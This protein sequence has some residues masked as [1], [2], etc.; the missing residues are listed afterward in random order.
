MYTVL[1]WKSMLVIRFF[2][3]LFF[4]FLALVASQKGLCSMVLVNNKVL[5]IY[6]IL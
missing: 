1:Y 3:F 5:V 4:S 6:Q 2:S